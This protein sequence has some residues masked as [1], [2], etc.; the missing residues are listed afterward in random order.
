MLIFTTVVVIFFIAYTCLIIWYL[1]G[2]SAIPVFA[3]SKARK[4]SLTISVIIPARNEEQHIG[5]LLDALLMQDYPASL[6]EIIVID[7][8]STDGT[9]SIVERFTAAATVTTATTR[10]VQLGKEPATVINSYKKLA[11]TTGVAASTGTFI[12]CTD[13]DCIPG[14]RWLSTMA[15]YREETGAVMIAA[16]V[17]IRSKNNPLQVF[18]AMDFLVLQGI[19]GAS[20][21]RQAHAMANGANLGYDRSA[22]DAVNGFEGIDSIASG[23]DMLL[24]QKMRERFPGRVRYLRSADAIMV[25]EP[26]FTLRDFLQQR[27]RW[28][29]KA[30]HYRDRTLLPVLLLVYLF[31]CLFLA[32]FLSMF[33]NK[34]YV[35]WFFTLW[36]GK[37]LIELP[38][39]LNVASFFRMSRY[40]RLLFIFQPIHVFYT[41]I[42]G[43]LG[44]F[45]SYQWKGRRVH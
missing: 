17:R 28:A 7:D 30:T 26:Q 36:V 38:F 10:L 13:A 12:I 27:I 32:L 25:T 31:N 15:A 20:V 42:S 24:M 39:F 40:A 6:T 37:T 35:P 34:V 45:G 3:F 21:H 16:P 14:P 8:H 33:F 18:Q 1:I 22:F 44:Q 5:A 4:P 11:I 9:A 23:D 41:V 19:T 43:L 2:W 29:S